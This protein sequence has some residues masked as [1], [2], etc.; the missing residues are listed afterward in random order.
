M[1]PA[2][3]FLRVRLALTGSRA[4]L[5]AHAQ[6]APARPATAAMYAPSLTP[7]RTEQSAPW[8]PVTPGS[9]AP[10]VVPVAQCAP[11]LTPPRTE[12][13]A[14]LPPATPGSTAPTAVP[15]AQ[16]APS[17]TP[18]RTEQSALWP[19]ATPGS[20]APTAVPVA[21]PRLASRSMWLTVTRRAEQ[22]PAQLRGL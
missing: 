14:P 8:P 13:S 4:T 22:E 12:Q 20:T 2:W 11:S 10:T 18:P 3:I 17:L 21:Q 7:P 6:R 1:A 9:T 5:V 19:P 16:F 15:V